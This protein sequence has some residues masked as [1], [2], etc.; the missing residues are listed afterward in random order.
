[1]RN[2]TDPRPLVLCVDDDP[3]ILDLE[4][5][6]LEREGYRVLTANNGREALKT[7]MEEPVKAVVLD[8][9]MPGM[10]GTDVAKVMKRLDPDIPKVLFTGASL[11]KEAAPFIE[12]YCPKMGGFAAL[13]I[14]LTA[15]LPFVAAGARLA[16]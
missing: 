3:T 10:N 5:M 2:S 6:A 1:M 8:Y 14:M 11:P 15:L 7:F 13:P 16:G 4:K 9:D 12:G